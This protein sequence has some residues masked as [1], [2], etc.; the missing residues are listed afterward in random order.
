MAFNVCMYL[1]IIEK[2]IPLF[3]HTHIKKTL[4]FVSITSI[5]LPIMGCNESKSNKVGNT[6]NEDDITPKI[7]H[8]TKL[9]LSNVST[10]LSQKKSGRYI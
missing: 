8:S 10:P 5:I 3:V 2:Y 7:Y 9:E 4:V 6:E 1:S